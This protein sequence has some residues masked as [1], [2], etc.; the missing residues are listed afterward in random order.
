MRIDWCRD[1]LQNDTLDNDL[2]MGYDFQHN[3]KICSAECRLQCFILIF[4]K[5]RKALRVFTLMTVMKIQSKRKRNSNHVK[6]GLHYSNRS[7]LVHLEAQKSIF[8]IHH[9]KAGLHYGNY[10]SKFRSIQKHRKIF[11]T[12]EK[13]LAQSNL[14]HSVKTTSGNLCCF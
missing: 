10:R 1:S 6:A 9:F 2:A 5:K 7:K 8:Y 14:C 4:V 13:A 3:R 12:L 11:S